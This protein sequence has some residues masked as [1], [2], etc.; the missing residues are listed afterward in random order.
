MSGYQE[1]G[2]RE[3]QEVY[4]GLFWGSKLFCVILQ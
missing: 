3:E 2:E 4:R 1:L